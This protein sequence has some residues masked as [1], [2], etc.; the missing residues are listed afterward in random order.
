MRIGVLSLQGNFAM[1]MACLQKLNVH[2]IEVRTPAAL[3]AL[4]G[5]IIPGGES[6][7]MLKLLEKDPQWFPA[8]QV[9]FKDNKPIFGTCAGVILLAKEVVPPQK[10]LQFMDITVARNA[11]GRQLDSHMAEVTLNL[12]AQ[13]QKISLA[14]IR[15]PKIIRVGN[16]VNILAQV[17]DQ[18]LIVEQGAI[19]GATCHP[20][21]STTLVHEYFLHKCSLNF[22]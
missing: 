13:P 10:S 5:L 11:Y 9:F 22:T 19:L 1:H 15:A 2:A 21:A 3:A 14:L 18:P 4:Q 20:E 8:L 17:G 7:V 6:S 12:G 16:G